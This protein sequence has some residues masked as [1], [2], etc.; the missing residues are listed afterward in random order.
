MRTA[1]LGR[2]R[3]ALTLALAAVGPATVH[4]DEIIEVTEL[5]QPRPPTTEPATVIVLDR[6]AIATI[7]APLL[8]DIVRSVPSVG[9]FR[10][11]SSTIADPTSQGLNLRGLGPSGVSRALVLRDG[12]PQND[13]FG[14]WVYWRAHSA[15]AIDRIE[16]QPSGAS[17]TFGNFGLGGVLAIASRRIDDAVEASLAGGSRE[18]LRGTAR[19]AH[20][21]GAYGLELDGEMFSTGGY[22]PIAEPG[23]I[24][25]AAASDHRNAG[26]R[27]ERV[28]EYVNARAF[29][30]WFDEDL[31]AGTDHTTAG[32]RAITYGASAEI[33]VRSSRVDLRAFGGDQQFDQTRARVSEDRSTAELASTQSTPSSSFGG[34]AVWSIALGNHTLQVGADALRVEGTATDAL[35]PAM[36]MP[37]SLV[38]RAAGG[39]QRFA[40][41][42]VQDG[43]RWGRL[44]VAGALRFDRWSLHDGERTLVRASGERDATS[45]A[46]RDGIEIDPRLGAFLHVDDNLGLRASVYRAFRAPTLNELYRPFQVGTV[47]TAA[48]EALRTETLWGAEAGPQVTAGT[49][50]ARVTAFY[51]VVSDPIFN[52]TLAEPQNGAMRQRQNV[53][54][55]RVAGA[56]FEA[57]WRPLE[58]ISATVAYTLIDSEITETTMPELAGKRLAQN[59][60]GRAAFSFVYAGP[61]LLATDIRYVGTQFED[62]LNR[63]PMGAYVLVD[64]LARRSIAY[65]ISAFASIQNA[66]DRR[67]LVGRAGIDTVGTPRTIL[68]GL[69]FSS[70]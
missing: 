65:G 42:F 56:E 67:Y 38:E 26:A 33:T 28:S 3:A 24:D 16:I 48:N 2:V 29:A 66:F 12:I 69:D 14:G 64:G 43:V 15:H 21:F 8:D 9:T 4:A 10:R 30:R 44:E 58:A 17:A 61:V 31:D 53:G 20:R 60:R 23:A 46:D 41:I 50:S 54:E 70:N 52:V 68:V 59:P 45:F 34:S 40:G 5:R 37:Q 1:A 39:E 49:V 57:S 32:A 6:E 36:P 55:A 19:V 27:I 18:T 13:P 63:L 47:L 7:P 25:H 22:V 62:D 11:S 51:N 35:S